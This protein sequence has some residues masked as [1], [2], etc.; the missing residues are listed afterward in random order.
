[1]KKNILSQKFY[2][3]TVSKNLVEYIEK[4]IP[5][6]DDDTTLYYEFPAIRDLD[7]KVAMP[8]MLIVSS[9]Y[10]I[11][12][13]KCDAISS[14]RNDGYI[15]QIDEELNKIESLIYAKLIKS[16]S[17]VIKK[18]KH[19]LN[20][21]VT[22]AL[23]LPN[24]TN[25]S[26]N[27]DNYV[28][29]SNSDVKRFF[30]EHKCEKLSENI[31]GEIFAILDA[32]TAIIRPKGRS[33]DS[34]DTSSK[35]YIMKKL[36]EEIAAFDDKQKYAALSQLEGP[37]RIRG[38]AGSGKTIILCMKA[39]ILHLK[40]PGC[41]ILYTFLT[42]SL[43]DYIELLI[44]RFYKALSDGEMPDFENA[45][46]IKHAWGGANIMGVYYEACRNNGVTPKR[47]QEAFRAN[48][49]EEVFDFVCNDLL[50]QT[51]GRLKKVYDYVLIDEAQD[52]KPS[53]YQICRE[54]V[55]NDC[56]VWGYDELQNIFK[57]NIQDTM[58]T[59]A[60]EY[61]AEG[62]NLGELQRTHPE[63][64]NDIV[65][66]KC[67][68]NPK[69]ILVLAHAIGFGIYNDNL[70]QTLQNNSHWEDLGYRVI[71][72]NC[73]PGD[74]MVI[75]RREE[76][77]PLSVSKYQSPD[78]IIDVYSASNIN[79]ETGWVC[80]EI[81][82]AVFEDKLRADDIIVI[83]IDDRYN[84]SYFDRI[85]ETLRENDIYTHN[86]SSNQYEKGFAE[87]GCVT[88]STVYKA[89][90][91]EAPMVF[92][93]GCDTFEGEKDNRMMRNKIFTAF[94]RAKAWLRITGI[95][96]SRHS[97]FREIECVQNNDFKLEF[98]HKEAHVI[99]RD[100][101]DANEKKSKNRDKMA[102]V[103]EELKKS[104]ITDNEL[105]GYIRETTL[106]TDKK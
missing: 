55:K 69:E 65:L 20:F 26:G 50:E 89:K 24:V 77:S 17:K 63:M 7:S 56:I 67:Y 100:L 6:I 104:G 49:G 60:N 95:G 75:E 80:N 102:K 97:L 45:I 39:A 23:F 70:I 43:Y 30:E 48:S 33:I 3:D 27:C 16:T 91:N 68:R 90:G 98:I 66:S 19:E 105:E 36:E 37:Q 82:K 62:I 42:K 99:K 1:M 59:F 94:T 47:F 64:D 34:D 103:F 78:E 72:G 81:C 73:K 29:Y 14:I 86:L 38:L 58:T 106:G 101:D 76:C 28:L 85:T 87:D 93:I 96:I 92:V 4:S 25:V 83:C 44:T 18:S 11:I 8:S 61:G 35:A 31:I 32:S 54:I 22:S 71:E 84:K 12:L 79:D 5:L 57:V 9:Y 46:Q 21:E 51:N 40:N 53:F 88:L 41:K 52:F 10:G 13:I 15:A 2:D 74:H